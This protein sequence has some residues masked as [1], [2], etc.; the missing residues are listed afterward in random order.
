[1]VKSAK[2]V[3][4]GDQNPKYIPKTKYF[5]ANDMHQ[6]PTYEYDSS[7]RQVGYLSRLDIERSVDKIGSVRQFVNEATRRSSFKKRPSFISAEKLALLSLQITENKKMFRKQ[8]VKQDL[9]DYTLISGNMI[10]QINGLREMNNSNVVQHYSSVTDKSGDQFFDFRIKTDRYTDKSKYL[11]FKDNP[12][13]LIKNSEILQKIAKRTPYKPKNSFLKKE[14]SPLANFQS[15]PSESKIT[16]LKSKS[17]VNVSTKPELTGANSPRP[18]KRNRV[19][20]QGS[21]CFV[22]NKKLAIGK[23]IPMANL[24]TD[25]IG[26]P[27]GRMMTEDCITSRPGVGNSPLRG[28]QSG[29]LGKHCKSGILLFRSSDTSLDF[30]RKKSPKFQ[31]PAKGGSGLFNKFS[32]DGNDSIDKSGK[33]G[34]SF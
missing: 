11:I 4:A 23:P 28:L 5:N 14:G 10:K 2:F 25:S 8:R 21:D 31:P 22:F 20:N 32:Y 18:P 19:D 16:N 3:N 13:H 7:N 34:Q 27:T 24:N 9:K 15:E 12:A 33:T 1:L 29:N 26:F 30:S 6:G 17:F